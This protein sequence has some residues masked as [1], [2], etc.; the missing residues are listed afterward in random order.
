MEVMQMTDFYQGKAVVVLGGSGFVGRHLCLYLMNELGADVYSI[1]NYSRRGFSVL[2]GLDITIPHVLRIKLE[3]IQPFA[4]FNLAAAVAGVEY[5]QNHQLEMFYE[6]I[7]LQ[8]IPV[9]VCEQLQIPHYLQVSSA[10]VYGEDANS[11]AVENN[12]G[13]EPTGANAG[14]SW[15]KRMGEKAVQWSNLPHAVIV[16]PSNI[17]GP[18]DWYDEKAHVIP[19]LIRGYVE[20]TAKIF[21][22]HEVIREFIYVQDVVKGMAFALQYGADKAEYNLGQGSLGTATSTVFLHTLIKNILNSDYVPSNVK[23]NFDQGDQIRFSNTDRINRLGWKPNV[24]LQTGLKLTIEDYL[25]R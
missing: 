22:G 3:S 4:V 10:C 2:K 23:S 9:Q 8:T 7:K 17:Y 13:G 11:P 21:D 12:L 15:A 1:D 18:G 20:R 25:G 16:R 14:Y 24:N 19:K 6:N 5:N